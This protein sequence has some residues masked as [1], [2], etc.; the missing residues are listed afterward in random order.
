[1]ICRHCYREIESS[2]EDPRWRS[3]TWDGKWSSVFCPVSNT[4][5]HEPQEN[6]PPTTL[7]LLILVLFL[8]LLLIAGVHSFGGLK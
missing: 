2:K 1:M 7:V 5:S 3:R 4:S 6:H 8:T